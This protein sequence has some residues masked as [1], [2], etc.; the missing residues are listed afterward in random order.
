VDNAF[1]VNYLESHADLDQDFP[2]SG[3]AE[4]ET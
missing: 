4:S 2:D 3:L 1:F